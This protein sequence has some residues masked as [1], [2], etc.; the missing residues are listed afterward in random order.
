MRNVDSRI[1]LRNALLGAVFALVAA[2]GAIAQSSGPRNLEE[3][4]AETQ[5][6]VDRNLT[7][8]VDAPGWPNFSRATEI[9]P[10]RYILP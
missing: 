9:R 10:R 3:L 5:K 7:R 6:R 4:K 2:S 1:F 8:I